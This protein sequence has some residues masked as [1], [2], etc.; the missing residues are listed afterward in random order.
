MEVRRRHVHAVARRSPR[1]ARAQA[2]LDTAEGSFKVGA[3]PFGAYWYPVKPFGD[4]VFRIQFTVEN[5]PTST[6]NGGVMIRTPEMRYSCPGTNGAPGELLDRERQRGDPRARSRPGFN[7]G[8]CPGV[9]DP[10][11]GNP[12]CTLTAPAASTDLHVGRRARSVPA[13][14]HLHRRLL[15]AQHRARASMTSTASTATR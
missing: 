7:F 6:R 14:G 11:I 13:R 8:V 2:T 3:S 1:A 10:A 12:L 15:R 9:I 5:T 4:V